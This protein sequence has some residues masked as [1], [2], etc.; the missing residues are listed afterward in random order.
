MSLRR[1]AWL[2]VLAALLLPL[3]GLGWLLGSE[4]GLR[5][6]FQR[7]ALA[8]PELALRA[9]RIEGRVGDLRLHGLQFELAGRPLRVESLALRWSPWRASLA[10]LQIE[11][12]EAQGI[13][14]GASAAPVDSEAGFDPD[15]F[16]WRFPDL[17]LPV[18]LELD[19]VQLRVLRVEGEPL[20]DRLDASAS[21]SRAGR[22]ELRRLQ[23]ERGDDR[24]ALQ[25]RL[26]AGS[27]AQGLRGSWRWRGVDGQLSLAADARGAAL[28]LSADQ[29]RAE[30]A[31]G[32]QALR[33][34]QLRLEAREA[35]LGALLEGLP[36]PLS[37]R[38][39]LR[40]EGGGA[41]IDGRLRHG[42]FD[43]DGLE[44]ALQ[45]VA[46]EQRLQLQGLAL[47]EAG[48]GRLQLD[49]GL[50]FAG[51]LEL[52]LQAGISDWPLT[53][54]EP[55][56]RLDAE[57]RVAGA[58]ERLDIG[59]RGEL[60]RAAQSLPLALE[61]R[62]EGEVL[63]LDSLR[64]E[65][66]AGRMAASGRLDLGAPR[67]LALTLQGDAFDPAWLDP[68][69]RGSINLDASLDAGEAEAGW[70]AA[71]RIDALSGRWFDAPLDGRGALAWQQERLT[72]T[73]DIGLGDGRLKL[74]AD[75]DV[76]RVGLDPLQLEQAYPGLA[77]RLSGQ[78][79][80][81]GLPDAP[82]I[83]AD[84]L[85]AALRWESLQVDSLALQGSLAERGGRRLQL[86]WKAARWSEGGDPFDGQLGV[87]GS[88]T[89]HRAQLRARG[90]AFE[91]AADWEG[92]WDGRRGIEIQRLDLQGPRSGDWQLAERGRIAWAPRL[93]IDPHCL[94]SD[95]T[96]LCIEPIVGATPDSWLLR[97]DG[98]PLQRIATITD[99]S[100]EYA[101]DGQ[102]HA[103]TVLRGG[104]AIELG[105]VDGR[106]DAG[107]VIDRS[108]EQPT[109]LLAWESA[110][111]RLEPGTERYRIEF[112]WQLVEEGRLRAQLELP[113]EA[114]LDSERWLGE[115]VVD[116]AQLQALALLAP[117]LNGARGALRGRLLWEGA[118]PAS[119]EL[120]LEGFGA[121]IPA[122]GVAIR[123]STLSLHQRDGQLVLDGLIDSGEGPLRIEG[124][125]Q[126]GSPLQAR[127][128]L[129]GSGVRVADT[130]RLALR[131]SPD[132]EAVWRAGRLRLRGEVGIP[133]ALIDLER[134]E[135][136]VQ[137]SPDVVVLDP[138]E[139]RR[140]V[141]SLP[142]DADLRVVLG[143]DVRLN[144]FGFEGTI[145]GALALR[146]APGRA[147]V[148][149]GTLELGGS[150]RAYGQELEIERGRLLFASSALDN[151]GIDLRARRPLREMEVGV[152]VRGSARRPQLS[153]WSRPALEQAEA[154]S[155]L[156]LGRPL[157]SASDVD[158]AQLGQ[159]AAAIG[160]NLLAAQVGG[161][162]GF[163]TFGVADSQALGGAAFTVG[164]Y[165]SPRLYL[166]YG[167][168]LFEPGQVVTLRYLISRHFDVELESARESRAG[169]NYR[170]ERD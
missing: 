84:L 153:L 51:P 87:E 159:A 69:L 40:G 27:A 50:G 73:L 22:L 161:R 75:G 57:L 122:L 162:L 17:G 38:L 128:R 62:L 142:I 152:E 43:F 106:L 147:M 16:E 24:F 54:A 7:A 164:K 124:A 9:E 19:A 121:R 60:R 120:A 160:G 85:G 141:A 76:L 114:P 86:D 53:A 88:P 64:S 65:G 23:I 80:L 97:I 41:R 102:L 70:D 145:G 31:L 154:L 1:L 169:I 137:T 20:I 113:A 13:D 29:G 32:V 14:I 25:G 47:R 151:P 36:E 96:R 132:I 107:R 166:S 150:Y 110:R 136:G 74:D 100:P 98:L 94:V 4:S 82:R 123:D 89:D 168:A 11:R 83:E 28:A 126:L 81:A 56:V 117:D 6:A 139:Q 78:L 115:L 157:A 91:L 63:H 45:W 15:R 156:V 144:G 133:S 61:A 135:A 44:G 158:G 35:R 68:R 111:W 163:D 46:A 12:I 138:R 71:L 130:R 8:L 95:G 39:G 125:L 55:E 3:L 165:L 109:P 105:A 155:W 67:T 48:G 2:S 37:L 5:F 66:E 79:S 108:A 92:D 21:L 26:P 129:A 131:V 49:G 116:I 58:L 34:W 72:G 146:E 143:E 90:E 104:D 149:R 42:G 140:G 59:L 148:G 33:S 119:G 118:G 127:V 99:L 93:M 77:G 167:V 18:S 103:Q 112:D 134:L 170:I 30:I 101:I 52:D 10:R